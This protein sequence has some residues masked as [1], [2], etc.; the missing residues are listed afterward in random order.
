[1]LEHVAL[2]GMPH[3]VVGPGH[4]MVRIGGERALVPGLGVVIAAELAAGV[5]DQG[6]D[7]G[8]VVVAERPQGGDACDIIA[9]V[10]NQ[11]VGA[12]VARQEI[13]GRAALPRCRLGLLDVC[14]LGAGL[15]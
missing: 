12:V 5:A 4:G 14:F 11:R 6:G 8:V 7:V 2:L 1:G 9:L 10:V 15:L 3:A 13:L